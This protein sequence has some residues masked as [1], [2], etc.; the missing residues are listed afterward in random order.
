MPLLLI[1]FGCLTFRYAEVE[2]VTFDIEKMKLILARLTVYK[3]KKRKYEISLRNIK[4]VIAVKRGLDK[5]NMDM[6]FYA[7]VLEMHS[8]QR[9]KVLETKSLR[10]I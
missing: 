2:S 7:L 1:F 10:R 8:G 4:E 6:T 3:C 5:A 9:C